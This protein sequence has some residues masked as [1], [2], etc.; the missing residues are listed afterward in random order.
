MA[1]GEAA[2]RRLLDG[3][4]ETTGVIAYND[5]MAIG[6][7]RGIRASGRTVPGDISVVGFDDV[8]IAGY[9]DP[10][11]TTVAQAIGELG[12][13]AVERL[14]ER[15]AESGLARDDGGRDRTP[16]GTVLPVRLV[17]RGSSGP[18][19]GSG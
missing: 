9:T 14:V 18:P 13:W 16:V 17:V 11:L 1:G 12:R 6:A 19:P 4:P 7:M 2:L 8:A 15:L 3:A 10:P 5:L